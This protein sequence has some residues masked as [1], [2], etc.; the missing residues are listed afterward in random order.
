M[1]DLVSGCSIMTPNEYLQKHNSVGQYIY[2][3]KCQH[4]DV[5]YADNW[6]KHKPQKV[7]E[8]ESVKIL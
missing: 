2:W 6:H 3:K 1:T 7:A 4:N 5:P 8:T